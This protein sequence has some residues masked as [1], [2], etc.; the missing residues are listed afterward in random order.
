[1]QFKTQGTCP[2]CGVTIEHEGLATTGEALGFNRCR[3]TIE[4]YGPIRIAKG[5]FTYLCDECL[6]LFQKDALAFS[7]QWLSEK[8][9]GKTRFEKILK[10]KTPVAKVPDEVKEAPAKLTAQNTVIESIR[11]TTCG[12]NAQVTVLWD[13]NKHIELS[14]CADGW[15]LWRY[16][17]ANLRSR[18]TTTE[19]HNIRHTVLDPAGRGRLICYC[20]ACKD[21]CDAELKFNQVFT[22]VAQT[23]AGSAGLDHLV[24]LLKEDKLLTHPVEAEE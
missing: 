22:D 8:L 10:V 16:P 24:I 6:S 2:K 17:G 13:D 1:M 3:I 18:T 9:T 15:L 12:C 20:P 19:M 23:L 4:K 5:A 14:I 21:Q 11:C 7:E